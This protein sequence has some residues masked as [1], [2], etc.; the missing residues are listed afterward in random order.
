MHSNAEYMKDVPIGNDDFKSLRDNDG[1]YVDK[2][3]LIGDIL[4]SRNTK[5]FL[6]TR[7][8][9]FGKTLNLSML[10]AFFNLEYKGKAEKW[11]EGLE[12]TDS[13]IAMEDANNNPVVVLDMKGL[14]TEDIDSFKK[15]FRE[16]MILLYDRFGYLKDSEKLSDAQKRM[17]L[18]VLTGELRYAT[19]ESSVLNL[20]MMLQEHWGRQTIILID[21][22]DNPINKTYGEE[23]QKQIV[24]FMKILFENTLKGNGSLRFSVVTGVMQ[25]AKE[26]IFSGLNNLYV[27]NVLSTKYDEEYGFTEGE[28]RDMLTYY[29]HPD[30]FDEVKDWY[31]GYRFGDA[32]IYNPW[33]VLNY[34]ANGFRP[35]PYWAGTS[36]N[37]VLTTLVENADAKTWEEL[38]ELGNGDSITKRVIPTITIDD[39]G[40]GGSAIYSVLVM[41]GYLNAVPNGNAYSLSIPNN[42]MRE[43][44]LT[45]MSEQL[46]SESDWM[47]REIFEAMRNED[48]Q[49]VESKLFDLLSEKIPFFA[50]S[51]E[52]DYQKILAVAA[53]CTQ[54]KYVTTMEEESGN[55]RVDVKMAS[56]TP[57]YPHIVM[58]LKKSDSND[59]DAWRKEAEGA[60][61]QIR[62]GSYHRG[63]SGRVLLYGI[64]FHGKEAKVVLEEA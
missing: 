39:I 1:Y 7:P 58:E 36:G 51:K 62:E 3:R 15:G 27:N 21:E 10:D 19:L 54:G 20:S 31:D 17:Y 18:D 8:R 45:T 61:R 38:T 57:R 22:Y 5:V 44:Y 35:A 64:C 41:S 49:M 16:R 59:P 46:G 32:E 23:V 60:V 29:G 47:F 11:F 42:E 56:R 24:R 6:F 25:I 28:V 43:V 40:K 53:M 37:D 4:S 48:V 30:R 52:S 26:S 34:V 14:N 12:I 63:L 33:S 9:R 13:S 55:G 2:T 50:I